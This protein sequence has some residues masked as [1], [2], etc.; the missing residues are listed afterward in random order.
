MDIIYEARLSDWKEPEELGFFK[1][2]A[3][4]QKACEDRASKGYLAK[5]LQWKALDAGVWQGYNDTSTYTIFPHEIH[6]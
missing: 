6:E 2:A 1:T 5:P 4:A 3:G